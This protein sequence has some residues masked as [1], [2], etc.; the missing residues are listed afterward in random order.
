MSNGCTI[1]PRSLHGNFAS[2]LRM[3]R[4]EIGERPSFGEREGELFVRIEHFGLEGLRIIRADNRVWN[5]VLIYPRH[6]SSDR[7]RQSSWPKREV[8]NLDFRRF[9]LLL[10]AC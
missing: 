1:S 2:H 8:I 7:H 10:R 9:Q 4:T 3:N 6:R 5:V